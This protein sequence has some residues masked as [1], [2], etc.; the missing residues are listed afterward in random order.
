[1]VEWRW[2]MILFLAHAR[3]IFDRDFNAQVQPFG[4]A[5]VDDGDRAI[6]RRSILVSSS[7]LA[8]CSAQEVRHLFER[9]LGRGKTDPLHPAFSD[10]LQ[11]LQRKGQVRTTLGGHDGVNLIDDHRVHPAQAGRGI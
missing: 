8:G 2:R 10:G 6:L 9:P 4:F 1:M 5:G 3:H 7:N 11:P